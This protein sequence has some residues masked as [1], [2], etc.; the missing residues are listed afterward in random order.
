MK[1][2][3]F[4]PADFREKSARRRGGA[5]RL[6]AGLIF[7]G[8]IGGVDIRSRVIRSASHQQLEEL[9]Q[10]YLLAQQTRTQH[11][12]SLSELD[13]ANEHAGLMAYLEH[14]WPM[15]QLLAVPTISTPDSIRLAQVRLERRLS[16][17]QSA[18]TNAS[19]GD[20]QLPTA[21]ASA[22]SFTTAA[23]KELQ[24]L[25]GEETLTLSGTTSN[26]Q[27][28]QQYVTNLSRSPL[29]K[30]AN[31]K[32]MTKA[33]ANKLSD[34]E[35]TQSEFVVQVTIVNSLKTLDGQSLSPTERISQLT[36]RP[37]EQP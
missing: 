8:L 16:E 32:G 30:T 13:Q 29:V 1:D 27:A 10:P 12:L 14:R 33:N 34:P 25:S 4:L 17:G 35:S 11:A 6:V 24:R 36:R 20:F 7:L 31:L 22:A 23:L 2:I 37:G 21:D 18:T 19:G 9:E 28:V 5:W 15:S 3:D 26:T